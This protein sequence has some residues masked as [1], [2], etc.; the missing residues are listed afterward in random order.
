MKV[1]KLRH[2]PEHDSMP[3]GADRRKSPRERYTPV[4]RTGATRSCATRHTNARASNNLSFPGLGGWSEA[5]KN[6]DMSERLA[7]GA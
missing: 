1:P 6:L 7:G 2:P 3:R 4:V 5:F